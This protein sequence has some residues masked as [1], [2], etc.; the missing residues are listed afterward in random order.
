MSENSF[1]QL[2]SKVSRRI[3]LTVLLCSLVPISGLVSLTV[4]NVHSRSQT[5]TSQRLHHASKNIGMAIM[6][7]LSAIENELKHVAALQEIGTTGEQLSIASLP[8]SENNSLK[9]IWMFPEQLEKIR[10]LT[11]TTQ[12]GLSSG[13]SY[14]IVERNNN[15]ISIKMWVPVL[16]FHGKR[17]LASGDID[18]DY[19]WSYAQGFLPL[20]MVLNIVDPRYQPLFSS[21]PNI[22]TNPELTERIC[23]KGHQQ[24]EIK[25]AGDVW[26]IGHWDLF[27]LAGF[28]SPSWHIIVIEPKKY[29]FAGLIDFQKNAALTGLVTFWIILLASSILVRRTLSPLKKLKKATQEVGQGNYEIKLDIKTGDEFEILGDS[30]VGM[31][32]KV[33]QQISQQK[34]MSQIIRNILGARGQEEIIQSL[35]KGLPE[36]IAVEQASLSILN[37][38]SDEILKT[39]ICHSQRKCALK[40]ISRAEITSDEVKKLELNSALYI[41]GTRSDFPFLLKPFDGAHAQEFLFFTLDI[42]QKTKAVLILTET[43]SWNDEVIAKIR[44]LADQLEISLS[45]AAMVEELDLLNVGILT[46]LART[47]DANSQWTHGHSERVTEYAISIGKALG[48]GDNDCDDLYHA[49]LLHDL[50]K[51]S[52]PAEILNKPGKLTSEEYALMKQHP[53]EGARIIEPIRAFDNIR[54]I[55]K[56]HH[57]RWDGK[58][59]P[60]GL[61]GEEI[62]LGARIMAVADV[63]DALFSDRPYRKGWSEEK[64]IKF[65][66]EESGSAFDPAVVHAFLQSC[67]I[68]RQ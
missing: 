39:W 61:K 5:E 6:A 43:V 14:L 17:G 51:V 26:F 16:D 32:S 22:P 19:L 49:G 65:L 68:P 63:Y 53:T 54:P 29:A 12:K 9:S 23:T 13:K 37:N 3:L 1:I 46:A 52:I 24:T 30:F 59:Y 62:C 67:K 55:V 47:V 15:K 45:R 11:T 64:V 28:N 40:E 31:A 48:L 20:N 21:D 58:G 57:E 25:M 8:A 60:D 50:G 41:R 2:Q 56:H 7:E 10:G 33:Q 18:L 42:N 38:P 66:N 4:Y 36:I 44:Q 35:F 34:N 27:L